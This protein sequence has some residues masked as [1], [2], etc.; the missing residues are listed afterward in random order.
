MLDSGC[1]MMAR[2]ENDLIINSLTG[3]ISLTKCW[4]LRVVSPCAHP[5]SPKDGACHGPSISSIM[6]RSDAHSIA[7]IRN[8]N[9][10]NRLFYHR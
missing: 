3:D 4:R 5:A 10:S 9:V 7:N 2:N 1:E 8:T 6:T